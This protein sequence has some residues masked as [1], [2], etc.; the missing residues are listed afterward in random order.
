MTT[1]TD[2]TRYGLA[3]YEHPD[4]RARV[5]DRDEIALDTAA[6][7]ECDAHGWDYQRGDVIEIDGEECEIIQIS[8]D[9]QTDDPRG[10]Y[11]EAVARVR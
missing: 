7:P 4:T 1:T 2:S 3:L 11:V 8:G 6:A 5:I 10:N 9:I